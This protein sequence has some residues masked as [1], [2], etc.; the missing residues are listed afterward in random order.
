M[1]EESIKLEIKPYLQPFE[2]ELAFREHG[3]ALGVA[4]RE[5]QG[6]LARCGLDGVGL[7][8]AFRRGFNPDYA[9][10]NVGFRVVLSSPFFSP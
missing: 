6:T 10:D 4:E 3:A 7:R 2:R 5:A 1:G 8:C 9:L